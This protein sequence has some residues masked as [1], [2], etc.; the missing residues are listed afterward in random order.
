MKKTLLALC[1]LMSFCFGMAQ[2]GSKE[3]PLTV[4]EFLEMGIPAEATADTYVKGYIVGYIA[5]GDTNVPTFNAD[6]CS[7]AT[8]I[9]IGGSSSEDEYDYCIPV[10]LPNT[11]IRKALN[12]QDHPENLGH[13]IILCG[14]REKYFSVSGLKSTSWYQWVGEAPVGGST[15]TVT[16][17]GLVDNCDDW[18]SEGSEIS[19]GWVGTYGLKVTAYNS[20][21][22]LGVASDQYSVSPEIKVGSND[23]VNFEWV[24]NFFSGNDPKDFISF[25]VRENGGDWKVLDVPTW[26]AGNNWTFVNSGDI[27]VAAYA[28]KTVQFGFHYTS[29]DEVSSTLEVKN[30]K[31]GGVSAPVETNTYTVA[32]VIALGTGVD[33]PNQKV[34]GYI[35]GYVNGQVYAEGCVFGAGEEASE[36][37]LLLADSATESDYNKCIPVQLPIGDIRSALNLK[38]N[39]DNLGKFATLTG[40]I[41]KYFGVPA[42]KSVSAYEL[43]GSSVTPDPVEKTKYTKVNSI[44]SGGKYAIMAAGGAA[45]ALAED[46]GYGYLPV[47]EVDNA[48][49]FE[50]ANEFVN[51]TFTA[52]DGGW[53]IQDAYGR[54]LYMSGTY[55]SFNVSAEVPT[56]G[57][58]W[59]VTFTDN[60]V[61]IRNVEKEKT[62]M[63]STTYTS[64]GAYPES[65]D[66]RV[67]PFLY[68]PAASAVSAIEDA[69]APVMYF[70]LQGVRVSN[71]ENG[72][73]I[74]RQ[75]NT[76]KKVVL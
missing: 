32:E 23:V 8:N 52:A 5:T 26:F 44:V 27:D 47:V 35:V 46:K 53:Y 73:F 3:N 30:F 6:N 45:T 41:V 10:Q 69:S 56:E 7:N 24:G 1:A 50:T 60:G 36:T 58:V 59:T 17:E 14:S 65:A 21:T 40:E 12:L 54:Y 66:D 42:L 70:N 9:L 38:A 57:Q 22:K 75:G 28:G 20:E 29:T 49:T 62:L 33:L 64:Y 48:D 71:P 76:A 25:V 11:D 4:D 34:K 16:Y 2:T 61:E 19:F 31:V 18:T 43:E 37:N 51:F 15:A 55:N 67:L 13:E 68:A 39:P 72:I 63:Y 74:V